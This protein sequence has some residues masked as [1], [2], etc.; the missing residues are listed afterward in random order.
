VTR[1]LFV[2]HPALLALA[3][4]L[5]TALVE[6]CS[7]NAYYSQS[8]LPADHNQAFRDRYPRA[9]RLFNAFDYGHARLSELLYTQPDE[10][11]TRLERQEFDWIVKRLLVD[12][13]KL[14]LDGEAIEPSFS[15]FAPE[16]HEMFEWS[17]ML[18]RQVYDILADDRIPPDRKDDEV[19]R[20][21]HYYRSRH[22]V[23][24]STTPKDM[25]LM[26]GQPYSGTFRAKAPKFNGLIWAYHWMQVAVYEA[27]LTGHTPDERKA[28]VTAVLDRFSSMLVDPPGRLPSVMPMTA[29]VAPTFAAR[30]P[31]AAIVFDNLHAMHD[32]V[33]DVLAAHPDDR[34]AQRREL[35][36]A[37]ARYR[38]DTTAVTTRAEWLEMSRAMNVRRMGGSAIVR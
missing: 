33:S 16:V 18:H 25:A 3:L 19:A 30:Y 9:D 28:L 8:Y 15:R 26:D 31:D 36:A 4:A 6:G 17:H 34:A 32:V 10:A 29:A 37:V 35:L 5:T 13:P 38:D 23:A 20:V 21:V 2:R 12:P 11:A 24:F 1:S 7:A 14:P 27:L 22:Q